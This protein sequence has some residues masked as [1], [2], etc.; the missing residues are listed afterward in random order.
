MSTD[1]VARGFA[2]DD[3]LFSKPAVVG[4][5]RSVG[6][7]WAHEA[8]R[9]PGRFAA[10]SVRKKTNPCRSPRELTAGSA[11]NFARGRR[12]L[13]GNPISCRPFP[14]LS[15]RPHHR[16]SVLACTEGAA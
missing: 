10:A 16:L 13:A 15:S 6:T 1:R 2:T 14:G 4:T 8:A 9:Q 3:P 11:G 12:G 5:T 7:L